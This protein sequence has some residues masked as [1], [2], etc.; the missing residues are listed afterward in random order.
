MN[1]LSRPALVSALLGALLGLWFGMFALRPRPEHVAP[2]RVA[3]ETPIPSPLPSAELPAIEAVLPPAPSAAPPVSS[4]EPAPTPLGRALRVSVLGW[5]LAAAGLVANQGMKSQPQSDF[6]SAGVEVQMTVVD[7][8]A[9]VEGAMARGGGDTLGADI[10]IVPLP[11]M[12]AALERI[13]A[14]QPEVFLVLGFS[15]GREVILGSVKTLSRDEL[16]TSD[17]RVLG[18]PGTVP[19]FVALS[20]L[21]VAGISA[22]HVKFV[23]PPTKAKS[24]DEEEF[25]D[26]GEKIEHPKLA[27][28]DKTVRFDAGDTDERKVLF[29]TAEASGL[30][31]YVAVAQAGFIHK[32]A[33]LLARFA[34]VWLKKQATMARDDSSSARQVAALEGAPEALA[35][36]TKLSLM[37][38]ASIEDNARMFGLSGRAGVTMGSLIGQTWGLWRSQEILTSPPP[39]D[40]PVTADV[41][42]RLAALGGIDSAREASREIVFDPKAAPLLVYRQGKG[43]TDSAAL[44]STV[45][46]MGSVFERSPI[47][48]SLRGEGSDEA[49]RAFV[50]DAS[51]KL[52]IDEKRFTKGRLDSAAV[53]ILPIP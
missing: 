47:R 16:G 22:S 19:A 35:L 30:V 9:K 12:V 50:T 18:Y 10:A 4:A 8:L 13:R 1:S 6:T 25:D 2:R 32:H 14:L 48:I 53:E 41:V 15:A 29:S 34:H 26:E 17:V 31:P 52:G 42:Q 51:L 5:E 28:T 33:D 3:V 44:L 45:G 23:P 37:R 11:L 43:K 27:A 49:F 38:R 39:A 20:M 36:L 40:M 46:W 21:D 7:Q 24:V